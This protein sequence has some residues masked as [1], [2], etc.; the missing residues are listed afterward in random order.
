MR[1]A[2][3]FL[4]IIL[5]SIRALPQK[6]LHLE[7]WDVDSLHLILPHQNGEQRV[8]SLNNLAVSLSF[9]DY[10]ESKQYADDAMNL[11]KE[12]NYEEGIAAAFRNY[13]QIYLYQ[14]NYPQALNNYLEALSLYEKLEKKHTAGW[15][16]FEIAKTHYFANNYEKTIEYAFIALDLF[17]ERTDEGYTVGNARDFVAVYG[18]IV[19]TYGMMGRY[20]K[21]LE[22]DLKVYDLVRK[23]NFYDIELMISTWSLGYSFSDEG[24]PDS[25]KAYFLKA[26]A[27]PDESLDMK[28]LKFRNIISLGWLYYSA[29]V[30]DSALYYM[31]TAF[32]FYEKKGFLYWALVTS[33]GLGYIYYKNNELTVAEKYLK[34]SERIFNEMLTKNS[35]FRNDSLKY[36]ASYG[37]ELYF[38]VPPARL[39][40]MMWA[41]SRSMYKL[42]YRINN[43]ENN[44]DK[45][46]KYHVA[47][48]G[49]RDTLN[50]IMRNRETIE[51]QT[52]YES[53]RKDQQIEALSLANELKESRLQQ[54]RSFLF[55]SAGLF[56]LILMLGYILFRQNKLKTDQQMLVL[57]QKLFRSQM[58]PHFIFNSLASIQNFIVKQ[59]SRKANIFL[60]R[61]SE[62]IRRILDNSTQEYI[63]FEKEISTIEN[64]LELQKVRY[65][66]KFDYS[67][68]VDE[69][70]D[71][72]TM[73][74]PPMLA[75]PIIENAIEHGIKH[76]DSKGN[77]HIRF[78]LQDNRIIFEVEDDGVGREKA[79]EILFKH[80]KDHKS[81]ATA[82]TLERIRVLNKKSKKKISF[83][84][85]DLKNENNKPIGTRV[86]FEIPVVF[87]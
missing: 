1:Y 62:L 77:I 71:T 83:K 56:I 6:Y 19:E 10:N 68:E 30:I 11:A 14:G 17:Q 87:S 74:I 8:N 33:R 57:Q 27:F 81:L 2:L 63:T 21:T 53:E 4:F 36:I 15:V 34:Q 54:N 82:I 45:A 29:G 64:Y 75:Q 20:D 42:L 40:E 49:A 44:F 31:K 61:F 79:Q 43:A 18:G 55:G 38:P 48:A 65:I 59:D 76:K 78:T 85:L 3:L 37:L 35:W 12:V 39:K 28:T 80:D 32:E 67:M 24:E 72:E 26:L 13:G 41:E 50:N 66:E 7:T 5:S 51:L 23:N 60:S 84:I 86:T 70:I 58:N 22:F 52:R 47:Y 69:A 46:L 25:A 16:C 9:V 73:K